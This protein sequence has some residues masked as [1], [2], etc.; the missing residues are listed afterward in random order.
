MA[1]KEKVL[2]VDD[3]A[4]MR[5][6]LKQG[7]ESIGY[8]SV[9]TCAN[10]R[11]AWELLNINSFDLIISDLNMPYID[12]QQLLDKVRAD[13]NF[14]SLPFIMVTAEGDRDP[15]MKAIASGVSDFI[16]KPFS[17][18]S[19]KEKINRAVNAKK[20][21]HVLLNAEI[22]ALK[23]SDT[24][25][26]NEPKS[27]KT[28]S[29]TI[30]VVDDHV[31]NIDLIVNLLKPLYKVKAAIN[32]KKG[33]AMASSDN[34]PDLI[35]LDIMM[36][37]MDGYQ[38][39]K[40]LKAN[41]NTADIPIIF[42]SAK[43]EVSDITKG[44]ALGAVDYVTKPIEPEILIARIRTHLALRRSQLVLASQIDTLIENSRL[45]E[46]VD[47]ITQHDLKN[48][49]SS[50]Y[51][52][53]ALLIDDPGST[54][55]QRKQF[56]SI[57]QTTN[58]ALQMVTRAHDLYKIEKGSYIFTPSNVD[59]VALTRQVITDLSDV[60]RE[61]LTSIDLRQFTPN[62]EII[63]ESSLCY[64]ILCNLIKNAIE[65]SPENTDVTIAIEE[66]DT[67]LAIRI[68]NEGTI[69]PKIRERLFD[70]YV[71]ANKDKGTGL[72][73]Y[74]AKIMTL[75]QNGEINFKTVDEKNTIFSIM[76]KQ[77]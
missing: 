41:L 6:T 10:G 50:I 43:G 76:F 56:K 24:V 12:G 25:A 23:P 35:L 19:L 29:E 26:E 31:S 44:F 16:V 32:G 49:L 22:L 17:P 58:H 55:N 45:K 77:P 9:T 14:S 54:E 40:E 57:K 20:P 33:L 28:S 5:Q 15:V 4:P 61:R 3:F 63:G 47:R 53:L 60:A 34:P 69:D 30:L 66:H 70:K 7:L 72:G 65:A 27:T 11:E 75:I 46:D 74:S 52:Q 1:Q 68:Y 71:T 42:L 67:D 21:E 73:T 38:V 39:C 2:V 13:E 18:N 64:S 62:T 37:E 8:A 36:P 51:S 59:I 48:P